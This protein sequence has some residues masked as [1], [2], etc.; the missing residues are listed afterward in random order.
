VV[1]GESSHTAYR[2]KGILVGAA[3]VIADA[4]AELSKSI[5]DAELFNL[6]IYN[7]DGDKLGMWKTKVGKKSSK[8]VVK[9]ATTTKKAKKTI[10]KTVQKTTRKR[11]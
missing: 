11:A 4:K 9:K 5:R 6:E 7:K 1:R 2:E 8:K 10:R 3:P